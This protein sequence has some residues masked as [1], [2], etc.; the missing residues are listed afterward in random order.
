[1]LFFV[2]LRL[3]VL[4]CLKMSFVGLVSVNRKFWFGFDRMILIVVV[5][6]V[7]IEEIDVNFVLFCM[8]G[9]VC[10]VL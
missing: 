8:V 10:M 5:L 1:M 2:V 6:G 3:V 4:F 7:V 9:F